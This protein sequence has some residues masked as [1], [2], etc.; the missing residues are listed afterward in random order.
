MQDR[1]DPLIAE[2]AP[3]LYSGRWHHTLARRALMRLLS[4]DRT[5]SI[6]TA[7]QDA[8]TATI[9]DTM[10]RMIARDVE[11]SGLENLPR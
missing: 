6:G 1:L 4:Y 10:A 8:P 5:V 2:R 9:M 11:V 3:W 7:L